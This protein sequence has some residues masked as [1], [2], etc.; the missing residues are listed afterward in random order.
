VAVTI[1]VFLSSL[2]LGR[3]LAAAAA[4][5]QIEGDFSVIEFHGV[6]KAYRTAKTKKVIL[7]NFTGEFPSGRNI[8]LLGINGAGKST[9][10]RLISGTESPDT[11]R[12]RRRVLISFPVNF[13]AF[14]G[15][16]SG[17]ENCRFVAR[18]YGVDVRS[19]ERFVEEFAEIGR[20]FDMPIVTYS[21]G[22]RSRISFGLSMAIDFD[23]YLVD[24]ALSVGDGIFK[25]RADALFET[26]AKQASLI[27]VSH[28]PL[29]V[30]RYCDMGAVLSN[31]E[32]LLFDNLDDAVA[33]YESI[34]NN[35][36]N[37]E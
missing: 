1:L 26:K 2:G 8:G 25:A 37:F 32:L 16:L 20:Y 23:C 7:D 12:I 24:E 33:H 6:S 3:I 5:D 13:A 17:R 4:P 29:T 22:M 9:L 19:V 34:T 36:G 35:L 11:G 30:R 21:A 31:G 18:I 14:K 15:N 10:L 28:S 27:I